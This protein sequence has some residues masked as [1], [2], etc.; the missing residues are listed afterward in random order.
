MGS[1]GQT[2]KLLNISSEAMTGLFLYP[3][4]KSCIVKTSLVP[5]DA[6]LPV[7]TPRPLDGW[8]PGQGENENTNIKLCKTNTKTF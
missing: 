7:S 2:R 4:S 3:W 5:R 1:E 8:S 6:A